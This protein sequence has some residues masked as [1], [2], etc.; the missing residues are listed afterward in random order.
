MVL[1]DFK[2]IAPITVRWGDMDSYGHVNNGV[3]F[4]YFE[5]ARLKY[6]LALDLYK[7]AGHPDHRPALASVT[8]N[9]RK[10][11]H[12]PADLE[13]GI[14]ATK[15]G[16]SSFSLEHVVFRAGLEEVIADGTSVVVLVD[17]AIGKAISLPDALRDAIRSLDGV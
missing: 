16:N 5:E 15:I 12:W 9:F 4:T 8:I 13:V 7:N 2:V 17:Y 1:S 14:R 11:L 10:Q 3:F 6:F